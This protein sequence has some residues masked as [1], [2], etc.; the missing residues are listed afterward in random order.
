MLIAWLAVF[1]TFS[2]LVKFSD[3][4]VSSVKA[5]MLLEEGSEAL[6]SVR[7]SSWTSNI[8]NLSS[9]ATYR[10]SY[11]TST[12]TWSAGSDLSMIDGKF[13]RTF[14]LTDVNRDSDFNVTTSGGFFDAGSRKATI[15]VSWFQNNAT[16]SESL[17]TYVFNDFNN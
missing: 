10:F 4:N 16:T 3:R 11:N 2:V 7:D 6:R 9:G 12:N 1:Y 14:V 13:D 8:A 17:E 15:T 5:A